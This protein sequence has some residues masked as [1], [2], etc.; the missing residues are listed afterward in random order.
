[1]LV[2]CRVE[3]FANDA[4]MQ[5]DYLVRYSGHPLDGHRHESGIAPLRLE[6]CQ[7]RGCHLAALAGNLEQAILMNLPLDAD[8]KTEL[9]PVVWTGFR[10]FYT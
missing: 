9:V 6:F 10:Y 7:V 4:I 1:M 2:L 5:I 8:G 3:Q